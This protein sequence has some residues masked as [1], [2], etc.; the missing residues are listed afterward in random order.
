MGPGDAPP[1]SARLGA[2]RVDGVA[3]AGEVLDTLAEIR[4]GMEGPE[5]VQIPDLDGQ[6]GAPDR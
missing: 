1:Q 2:M 4:K 3:T 5:D 6:E